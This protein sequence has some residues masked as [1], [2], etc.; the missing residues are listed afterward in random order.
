M[1]LPVKYLCVCV[2]ARIYI[3]C[4]QLSSV[5]KAST[6]LTVTV[7]ELN[8]TDKHDKF[9]YGAHDRVRVETHTRR[10]LI[11]QRIKT[12]TAK[13]NEKKTKLESK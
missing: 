6:L 4:K 9:V 7:T 5:D 10:E 3:N 1:Q 13:G 12:A 11:T 2:C 8:W